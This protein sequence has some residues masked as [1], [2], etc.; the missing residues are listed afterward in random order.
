[1]FFV[2]RIQWGCDE[3]HIETNRMHYHHHH[4]HSQECIELLRSQAKAHGSIFSATGDIH[5]TVND[6][7]LSIALKQCKILREKLAKDKTLRARREKN[8]SVALDILERKGDDPTKLTATDLMALL[9]W[10][11]HPQVAGMKKDAKFVAWMEIK[12]RGKAPPAFDKWTHH[13]EEQLMD[14][15]PSATS[16]RWPTLR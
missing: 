8:E 2:G 15:R 12:R 11:Q 5:L 7:F 9:T 13:D 14:P 1:M 6:I 16:S 3:G 4:S 10:H